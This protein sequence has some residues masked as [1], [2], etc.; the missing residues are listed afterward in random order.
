MEERD[1][2]SDDEEELSPSAWE[3]EEQ[4]GPLPRQPTDE[5]APGKPSARRSFK[6]VLSTLIGWRSGK[7]LPKGSREYYATRESLGEEMRQFRRDTMPQLIER[8]SRKTRL[9]RESPGE[10]TFAELVGSPTFA[11]EALGEPNTATIHPIYGSKSADV[12]HR[13]SR[14]LEMSQAEDPELIS[15]KMEV[16]VIM[17]CFFQVL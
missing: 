7:S 13:L 11:E 2:E 17:I 4:L 1:H 16:F 9:G 6:H 15:R 5:P 14:G 3:A 8:A 10:R 12:Q